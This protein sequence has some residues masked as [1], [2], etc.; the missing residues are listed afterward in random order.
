MGTSVR[1]GPGV[2]AHCLGVSFLI[3]EVQTREARIKRLINN[4]VRWCSCERMPPRHQVFSWKWAFSTHAEDRISSAAS[5]LRRV[6]L[7][8]AGRDKI[9]VGITA[10]NQHLAAGKQC[11]GVA[12]A[13]M[14]HA[15][16]CGPCVAGEGVEEADSRGRVPAAPTVTPRS[17]GQ[18]AS[19]MEK[20]S[21]DRQPCSLR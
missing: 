5:K 12:E 6:N 18:H 11:R 21:N 17:A 16:G 20:R 4:S 10:G 3:P 8:A 15:A 13:S 14:N 7:G 1:F 9:I 2:I 19:G